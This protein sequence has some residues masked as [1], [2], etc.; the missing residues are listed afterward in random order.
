M[1]FQALRR[2]VQVVAE[3]GRERAEAVANTAASSP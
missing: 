2:I 1:E 3:Q